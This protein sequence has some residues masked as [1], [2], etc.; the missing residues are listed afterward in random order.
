MDKNESND[1]S[2]GGKHSAQSY[3]KFNEQVVKLKAQ[4]E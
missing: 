3:V 1:L 2:S 4:A